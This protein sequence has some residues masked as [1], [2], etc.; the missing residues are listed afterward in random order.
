MKVGIDKTQGSKGIRQWPIKRYLYSP[1]DETQNFP[2]CRL[3]LVLEIYAP[4][5]Q[6]SIKEPKVVKLTNKKTL[7]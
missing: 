4:I 5:N 2:L 7:L 3:Q 6:N 1:N